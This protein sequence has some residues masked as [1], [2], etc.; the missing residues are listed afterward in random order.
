[1][2]RDFLTMEIVSSLSAHWPF[3]GSA[4]MTPL[5]GGVNN[6]TVR[7]DVEDGRSFVLRIARGHANL[8]RIRYEVAILDALARQSLPFDIPI[9]IRTGADEACVVFEDDGL[10][11]IATLT[12]F[13]PGTAPDPSDLALAELAGAALAQLDLALAQ[14]SPPQGPDYAPRPLFGDLAGWHPA[15]PDPLHLLDALAV[16]PEDRRAIIALMERMRAEIPALYATLP[17]QLVHADVDPSNCL[18]VEGRITALLDFEFCGWDLRV[19]DLA[20]TLTWWGIEAIETDTEWPILDRIGRGFSRHCRLS[21][22]E[23]AAL[24]TVMRLRDSASLIH[25]VGRFRQGIEP[26][27]I[28]TRRIR[29]TLWHDA[30]I[31]ANA[32]RLVDHARQWRTRS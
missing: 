1:M 27:A 18:A 20:V 2:K 22:A 13:L 16:A 32:G 31:A 17:Q 24:P 9:P 23:I 19:L 21:D 25:R 11:A 6:T 30:W 14:I 15:V 4:T 26:E 29:F 8:A 10:P 12:A 7:V 3:I 5:H 28:V